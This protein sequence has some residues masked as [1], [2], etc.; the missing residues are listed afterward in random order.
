M[1]VVRIPPFAI[2]VIEGVLYELV[3]VLCQQPVLVSDVE[4][5]QVLVEHDMTRVDVEANEL[6]SDTDRRVPLGVAGPLITGHCWPW[7]GANNQHWIG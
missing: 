7:L 5:P 3:L 2:R 6:L 1:D 4:L